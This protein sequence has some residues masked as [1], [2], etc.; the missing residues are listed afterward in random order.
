MRLR[1]SLAPTG[2]LERTIEG[3]YEAAA[4]PSGLVEIARLVAE[5]I[6]HS[7]LVFYSVDHANNTIPF[8]TSVGVSAAAIAEH[9]AYFVAIDPRTAYLRATG[10]DLIHE[11]MFISESE[12][13]H[14]EYYAWLQRQGSRYH[15][16]TM[17][18]GMGSETGY[19]SLLRSLQ[20]GAVD[21]SEIDR[22]A[23][24]LP[25]LR[26]ACRLARRFDGELADR[27]GLEQALYLGPA[28]SLILTGQSEIKFAS[29]A[30]EA[31]LARRDPLARDVANRLTAVA[32]AETA[33][34][35]AAV[36]RLADEPP[37]PTTSGTFPATPASGQRP[38]IVKL[39]P[40]RRAAFVSRSA[41]GLILAT[42]HAPAPSVGADTSVLIRHFGLTAAEAR[43]A[44]ALGN[45]RGLV[46][47][48]RRLG[49]SRETAK[50]CLRNVCDKLGIHRQAQ[51]IALLATLTT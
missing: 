16:S 25:H 28:S 3:V 14:S 38:H 46:D 13:N 43:L 36:A 11:A 1:V 24:L 4:A 5:V 17:I 10:V 9:A 12:I 41:R 37:S 47:A 22:F 18:N 50:G 49:I 45:G 48:S 29:A 44:V 6:P 20:Q 8:F 39:L 26:R 34:L 2:L 33:R 32:T 31:L 21:Q 15:I 51:L 42:V 19:F 40:L 30:A 35:R 27:A 23:A 7:G